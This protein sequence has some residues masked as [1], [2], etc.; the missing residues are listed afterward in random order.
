MGSE[1]AVAGRCLLVTRHFVGRW[2]GLESSGKGSI[3][4]GRQVPSRR[5]E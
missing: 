3:M 1:V 5:R 2:L 4:V